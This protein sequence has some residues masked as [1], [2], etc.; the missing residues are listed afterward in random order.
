MYDLLR[1]AG[2]D[3]GDRAAPC[4]RCIARQPFVSCPVSYTHLDV[5]KRQVYPTIDPATRTFPVEIQLVN[6]A[7]RDVYQRQC[8]Q[9]GR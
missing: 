7:Q 6:R 5:D 9:C 4:T 8:L 3:C 2:A 1:G